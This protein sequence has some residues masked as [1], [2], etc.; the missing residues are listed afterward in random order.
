VNKVL[1]YHYN[2]EAVARDTKSSHCFLLC[3][4]WLFFLFSLFVSA[5]APSHSEYYL[6]Q[7]HKI[8]EAAAAR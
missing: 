7:E 8:I 6:K 1:V 4:S 3:I 5:S 2:L